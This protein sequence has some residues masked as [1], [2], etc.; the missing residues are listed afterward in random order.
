MVNHSFSFD[1]Q[2]DSPDVEVLDYQYGSSKVFGTHA[3]KERIALGQTFPS[4]G[5]FGA[6]PRG[7][8]IY[9]KWRDKKSGQI[10][11]EKVDLR[12][13]LPADIELLD[14]HFVIKGGKLYVYLVW[15]PGDRPYLPKG[16]LK[17]YALQ[18]QVQI[19]PDQPK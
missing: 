4:A 7:E 18:K 10:F 11:E 15:P 8:F 12:T 16:P 19:Y 3:D 17:G 1:T 14:V 13:R 2:M 5:I 9:V 6:L